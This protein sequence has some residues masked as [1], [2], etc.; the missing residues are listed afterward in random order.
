MSLQSTHH[1][2]IDLPGCKSASARALILASCA[3]G[4]S[5]LSGLSNSEDTRHLAAALSTLGAGIHPDLESGFDS[6]SPVSGEIE[7]EGIA[8]P[9]IGGELMVDAGEAAT[10]L[11]LLVALASISPGG[12]GVCGSPG[13]MSRPHSPLLDF[14]VDMGQSIEVGEHIKVGPWAL[15]GG[16]WLCPAGS[17]SQFHSGLALAAVCRS[18]GEEVRLH[19]PPD[20]PSPGYFDLT[21]DTILDFCGERSA[22]VVGDYVL[23]R[24][25]PPQPCKWECPAD[26]SAASFFLVRAI[27]EQRPVSFARPW[28][29]SHPEACFATWLLEEGLLCEESAGQFDVGVRSID[30]ANVTSSSGTS[31]EFNVDAC[32]DVAPALAVLAA[33]LPSGV[34]ISGVGRLRFK[35]SDRFSG[36]ARLA[37]RLGAE[38]GEPTSGSLLIKPSATG[39]RQQA[40]A[41]DGDHRL[42]MAAAV[43]GLE[44][45]DRACVAKSFPGFWQ[46]LLK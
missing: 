22:A 5:S 45:D 6:S 10:N 46:E 27:L 29:P 44:V 36:I 4:R 26:A 9:P 3:S 14:L 13:L 15:P 8:G 23:L 35:E 25:G 33:H 7:I 43:A 24:P 30:A 19:L 32:P 40:F 11:R 2:R 21:I 12:F 38:V 37:T 18:A 28:S 16:D 42:A 41:T 31:L 1:P 39:S 20:L 34:V 17:S